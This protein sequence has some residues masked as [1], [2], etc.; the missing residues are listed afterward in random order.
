MRSRKVYLWLAVAALLLASCSAGDDDAVNNESSTSTTAAIITEATATAGAGAQGLDWSMAFEVP[1]PFDVWS[2]VWADGRFYALGTHTDGDFFAPTILWVSADG[3][4]WAEVDSSAFGGTASLRQLVPADDGLLALGFV[5]EGDGHAAT[6]WYTSDGSD[7]SASDLGYRVDSSTQPYTTNLLM[8]GAAAIGP[9]GAVVTATAFPGLDWTAAEQAA[10]DALPEELA[11]IDPDRVG[12]T[13][14]SVQVNIGPFAVFSE[15]LTTLGLDEVQEAQRVTNSPAA[16]TEEQPITF[17]SS[18]LEE[19][20]VVDGSPMDAEYIMAM[21][22]VGGEY[23]AS[24]AG[25]SFDGQI[26]TS[27]DGRAWE[28]VA[29]TPEGLGELFQ[30]GDRLITDGW[31]GDKRVTMASEDAG[32]SWVELPGLDLSGSWITAAGPAGILATGTE[33]GIGWGATPEPAVVEADGY[34]VTFDSATQEFT[35]A[36]ADGLTVL[37]SSLVMEDPMW[38]WGFA[39]PDEMTFD[40]AAETATVVDPVGGDRLFSLSFADLDRL[41]AGMISYGGELLAFSPNGERWTATPLTEAFGAESMLGTACV[42]ADRVVAVIGQTLPNPLA[43][44]AIWVGI[45]VA[46][47]A[48]ATAPAAPEPPEV[49]MGGPTLAWQQVLDLDRGVGSI[50]AT[51]TGLWAVSGEWNEP[52]ALWHS[53]DGLVWTELDTETLF[54]NGTIV[55]QVVEGGPGLVAVGFRPT[56][57]T[58]EAVAWTSAEGQEW[59]VSPIGY[60]IPEPQRPFETTELHFWQVAAGQS[61]AVVAASVWEGFGHDELEGNVQSALPESLREYA[62]GMG[63]MIDP[64]NISVSVGPFQVFAESVEN[65]AVDRDLFDLYEQS[66]SGPGGRDTIMFVTDDYA[67]WQQVDDW[68]GGDNLVSALTATSDGFLADTWIWGEQV[69]PFASADGVVW[70]DADLP[71]D[72]GSVSW[73]GEADGRLLMLGGLGGHSVVWESDDGGSTWAAWAGLPDGIGDVRV[74]GLGLVALGEYESEWWNPETW[75]PTVVESGGY[76]MTVSAGKDGLSIVDWGGGTVLTADLSMA[77]FGG[78]EGLLLPDFIVADHERAEFT[79]VEPET[80]ETLMTV[81]YREMQNSFK[82]AEQE[83]AGGPAMFVAYSAD[84]R[85]WSEQSIHEAT[86]TIGWINQL[87]VGDDFAVLVIEGLDDSTSVWRTAP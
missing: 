76:T 2:V 7:W 55:E 60:T 30:V 33:G 26:Y 3:L 11:G 15:S 27:L 35:V 8:F 43:D 20:T 5:P 31:R 13:P 40:Y 46:G 6:A 24:A 34:T 21:T 45:P 12:T 51:A 4:E 1:D 32:R 18:D 70:H 73:F 36:D 16:M 48:V 64:W 68:P 42:S 57:T 80:G 69:G 41:E 22:T 65:L 49:A 29:D 59:E 77:G 14:E 37:S 28:Q 86:G 67:T 62:T 39:P 10:F 50:V 61:G 75:G 38:G 81:P 66:I 52:G 74:G 56:G 83:G 53:L 47:Q 25:P 71:T 78:P 17:F 9:A 82:A 87:A 58:R 23:V 54:G 63:V 79:V 44:D 85:V 84:G 19:W 72:P